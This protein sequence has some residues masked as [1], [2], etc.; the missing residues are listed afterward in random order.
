MKISFRVIVLSLSIIFIGEDVFSQENTWSSGASMLTARVSPA[1]AVIGN[2]LYVV[3]GFTDL[4]GAFSNVE[5]YDPATDSWSTKNPMPTARGRLAVGVINDI[6]YAVGGYGGESAVEAFDPAANTWTP[7]AP[8]TAAR[9]A[10]AAGVINGKLYVVGGTYSPDSVQTLEEYDPSTN[11]W[12]LKAPMPTPR[13]LLAAGVIDGK[14]YT[15]GGAN[16]V[17]GGPGLSVLE[18][19]DPATNTWVTK[20]PMPTPRSDLAAGVMDGKL[21]VVG[22]FSAGSTTG[23]E[24][25]VYDPVSDS[26][27][28]LPLMPTPRGGLAAGASNGKLYTAGG[29]FLPGQDPHATLEQFTIAT[30]V[31]VGEDYRTQ[32]PSTFTLY[33]NYPNPFNPETEIRFEILEAA[34]VTLSIY[35][36]K[37]QLI[38]TLVNSEHAANSYSIIW[39]GTNSQG[40]KVASAVYIYRLRA[41]N[42]VQNRRMLLLK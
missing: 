39:N 18:V 7:K 2:Q 28:T 30:A 8:L 31:S 22:G 9:L 14:L 25:E 36:V 24:L 23:A 15:V 38:N 3:G 11:T 10:P 13:F 41:G 40:E 37:G 42:F 35:D 1:A 4:D 26:W 12:A 19:Y 5:A 29:T 33:Q 21:Y 34:N 6:L 27:S 16:S 17:T 32:E 20:Q